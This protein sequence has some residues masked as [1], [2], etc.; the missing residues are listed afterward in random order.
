MPIT[1]IRSAYGNDVHGADNDRKT[2]CGIRYNAAENYKKY[3]KAGEMVDLE[4]ITCPKCKEDLAKK[5]IRESNKQTSKQQKEE[6][7]KFAQAKKNGLVAESTFEEYVLNREAE[8]SSRKAMRQQNSGSS[9]PPLKA[10]QPLPP[11]KAD[12]PL[13]PAERRGTTTYPQANVK[14]SG[15]RQANNQNQQVQASNNFEKPKPNSFKSL[16]ETDSILSQ[17]MLKD[18]SVP[19]VNEV[20]EQDAPK[21]PTNQTI[22]QPIINQSLVKPNI[23]ETSKEQITTSDSVFIDNQPKILDLEDLVVPN[24]NLNNLKTETSVKIP[25]EEKPT[26]P[27]QQQV[28]QNLNKDDAL[29]QFIVNPPTYNSTEMNDIS[30]DSISISPQIELDQQSQNYTL[31]NNENEMP[32]FS[33]FNE[34]NSKP[35]IE[36]ISAQQVRN[37][38]LE[39]NIVEKVE[40]NTPKV[41]YTSS[42]G[43]QNETIN[44]KIPNHYYNSINQSQNEFKNNQFE[45]LSINNV[46]EN[47]YVQPQQLEK[48]EVNYS[49]SYGMVDSYENKPEIIP[50][51]NSVT[52]EPLYQSLQQENAFTNTNVPITNSMQNLNAFEPEM[53]KPIVQDMNDIDSIFQKYGSEEVKD[54]SNSTYSNN[55]TNN[56]LNSNSSNINT[57]NNSSIFTSQNK[58]APMVDSIEEALSQ[59][60]AIDQKKIEKEKN[61]IVP[62]YIPYVPP[63]QKEKERLESLLNQPKSSN[64]PEKVISAREARRLAKIDAKF[65]KELAERGFDY[66][67]LKTNDKRK[68]K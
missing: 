25:V 20:F 52:Q 47:I 58:A 4:D 7:K 21:V 5:I 44:Q 22:Q 2:G 15:V 17:F 6:R 55:I 51:Q 54:Q 18:I 41:S 31:N 39:Q 8:E 24:L 60:G 3:I 33:I 23:V 53:S 68:F 13:T 34:L 16:A 1:L 9:L 38:E 28:I 46:D 45:E 12:Q 10:D 30:L 64:Q 42:Y 37:K 67:D 32:D 66:I 43:M 63:S 26:Q 36:D 29:S 56:N 19:S 62:D 65:Q 27:H 57:I 50:V 14:N 49:N 40:D 48:S 35:I 11:L 61:E 59:L